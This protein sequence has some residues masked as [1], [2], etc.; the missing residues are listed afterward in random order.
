M[1]IEL[2]RLLIS[3]TVINT[4]GGS[5]DFWV[6][7]KQKTRNLHITEVSDV[8]RARARHGGVDNKRIFWRTTQSQIS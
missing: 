2:K 4:Q 3:F 8:T 5:S 6:K 7:L 1:R